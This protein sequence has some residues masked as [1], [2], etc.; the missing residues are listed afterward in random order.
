MDVAVANGRIARLVIPNCLS[1]AG[2]HP[3]VTL[4][5]VDSPE[6]VAPLRKGHRMTLAMAS[7]SFSAAISAR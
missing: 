2:A 6:T 5:A 3:R 4:P 7:G 1:A